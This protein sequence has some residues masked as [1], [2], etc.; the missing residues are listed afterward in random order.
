VVLD[1]GA[2]VGLF[3]LFIARRNPACRVLAF[4]PSE[5]F[6]HL[7][8]N[9]S[10]MVLGNVE[11]HRL[12]AGATRGWVRMVHSTGRSI[13]NRA[14]IT[15]AGDS[16]SVETL[17]LSEVLALAKSDHVAFLKMDI[18]GSEVDVMS[19]ADAATLRRIER[20]GIEYHDNL[21]P[22]ALKRLQEILTPTHDLRV[23]PAHGGHGLLFG[24]RRN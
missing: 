6:F 23:E 9:V 15:S 8:R 10:A 2:H 12:A 11:C 18:E 7:Q 4:E 14:V 17:P 1:L 21:V 5:N 22:G 13:D 20:L 24:N 19:A 16:T 3:S